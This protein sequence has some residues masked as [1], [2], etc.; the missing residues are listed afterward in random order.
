MSKATRFPKKK[1]RHTQSRTS[2]EPAKN[3]F[4]S[5]PIFVKIL[6]VVV[7][8]VICVVVYWRIK[9]ALRQKDVSVG[10]ESDN[11]TGMGRSDLAS[12]TIHSGSQ[13]HILIHLHRATPDIVA[14]TIF[15]AF[16]AAKYP[17]L[18]HIHLYQEICVG[19]G[20][21]RDVFDTYTNSY[22]QL[23]SWD[24][25]KLS[26]K[27][28]FHVV[29]ENPTQSA[30]RL[31]SLLTLTHESVLPILRSNDLVV[32]PQSFY[33]S[34]GT[35]HLFPLTF[36]Q[37]YDET[38]RTSNL[39]PNTVYSGQLPRTSQSVASA[40]QVTMLT[41]SLTHAIGHNLVIPFFK[42]KEH[43][44]F[45]ESRTTGVCSANAAK[46]LAL[47]QTGFTSYVTSDRTSSV[48]IRQVTDSDVPFTIWRFMRNFYAPPSHSESVDWTGYSAQHNQVLVRPVPMVGVHED[49]LLCTASS[50]MQVVQ[51]AQGFGRE[52]L[53][54]G[55]EYT[56]TLI[57][58]NLIFASGVA[59]YTANHLPVGAV[60]DHLTGASATVDSKAL[61]KTRAFE[62]HNWLVAMKPVNGLSGQLAPVKLDDP[63]DRIELCEA[64][65]WYAGVTPDNVT[66]NGFLGL[67]DVD[68]P[69]IIQ[70]KFASEVEL[71]RQ[72]RM[73][74][75]I[76]FPIRS[77]ADV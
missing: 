24:T 74:A 12:G 73:L 47:D 43:A 66:Q 33:N 60:F 17:G 64:Y 15:G 13:V 75:A 25:K 51:F 32:I 14:R 39:A 59:M 35:V 22:S 6:F 9:A 37:D 61:Q 58:S 2:E 18:V 69:N 65:E 16:E 34:P 45:L 11:Q 41:S 19:D 42:S 26:M 67:T 56:Q 68:G 30:G 55:P 63:C 1:Q 4:Q 70:H 57:L 29:N 71:E 23:H 31:V 76:E 54:P 3:W 53:I 40:A 62:P 48:G 44:N 5:I 52:Y 10:F 46:N 36:A 20:Y 7:L 27:R 21:S 50:W 28:N 72:K 77:T 38:L 8:V 49:M